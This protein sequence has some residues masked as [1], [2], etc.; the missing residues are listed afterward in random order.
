MPKP[1][2][3]LNDGKQRSI[4]H[5][6]PALTDVPDD[7][8]QRRR[9]Q[10]AAIEALSDDVDESD[11]IDEVLSDLKSARK[12]VAATRRSREAR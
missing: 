11:D 1:I 9:A 12:A 8:E 5:R 7:G 4:T 3:T 2:K 10:Y 6:R